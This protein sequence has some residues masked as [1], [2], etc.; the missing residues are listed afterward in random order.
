MNAL[1]PDP[2][3]AG[4]ELEILFPLLRE[5]ARVRANSSLHTWQ[6]RRKPFSR[7]F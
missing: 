1:T 3:P 4:E 7:G 6:Q 2:S 5:R